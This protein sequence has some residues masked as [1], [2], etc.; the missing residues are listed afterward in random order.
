MSAHLVPPQSLERVWLPRSNTLGGAGGSQAA[1]ATC[2]LLALVHMGVTLLSYPRPCDMR[3]RFRHQDSK[4][5]AW[6]ALKA[7]N[8]RHACAG[9]WDCASSPQP[10]KIFPNNFLHLSL[11]LA[12]SQGTV[13][14]GVAA[15]ERLM[16]GWRIAGSPR[17][18]ASIRSPSPMGLS[19]GS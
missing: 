4:E 9:D 2:W 13:K 3:H 8:C 16:R 5:E 15:L 14:P 1:A 6:A 7:A 17:A 10:P 12:S 18:G 19:P 11:R